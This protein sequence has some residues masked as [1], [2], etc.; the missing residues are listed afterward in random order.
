MSRASVSTVDDNDKSDSV[1]ET[2]DDDGGGGGTKADG[3]SGVDAEAL[4]AGNRCNGLN[5]DDDDED[6]AGGG[7]TSN[8]NKSPRDVRTRHKV[9]DATKIVFPFTVA[10]DNNLTAPRKIAASSPRFVASISA[11]NIE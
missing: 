5:A 8:A 3:N 4:S 9:S 2:D 1:C 6:S 7:D 10:S 11:S